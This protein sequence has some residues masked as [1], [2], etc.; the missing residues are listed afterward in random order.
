MPWPSEEELEGLVARFRERSLPHAE[1]THHAHL[2]VG[3]WHVRRYGADEALARLRRDIR[4]L[5]DA[6][7][8]PNSD[9]RGYH[10]T[11]TRAYVEL[12]AAALAHLPE[13]AGPA[14]CAQAVLASRLGSKDALLA[15]YSSERLMSVAARRAW[16]APDRAPLVL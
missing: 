15:F 5:N 10:E 16:V 2:A 3:T 7:G 12:I 1:W 14:A 9:T 6:H 11:I 8:T 13:E 4:S